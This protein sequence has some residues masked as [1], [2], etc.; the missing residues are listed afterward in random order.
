MNMD[1][2]LDAANT[3]DKYLKQVQEYMPTI[4]EAAK[5]GAAAAVG[6]LLMWLV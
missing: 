5:L 1:T 6:A 3:E 4:K 2:K